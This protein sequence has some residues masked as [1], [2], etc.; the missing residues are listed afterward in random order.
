MFG[1]TLAVRGQI[2]PT[3]RFEIEIEDPIAERRITHAYDIVKLPVV[4]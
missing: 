1:G 4:G 2:R 3:S